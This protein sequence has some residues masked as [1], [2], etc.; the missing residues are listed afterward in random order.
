MTKRLFAYIGLTMLV[1]LAVVFYF[2]IYGTIFAAVFSVVFIILAVSLKA[3]RENRRV[4]ILIA[5]V[6]LISTSYLNIYSSLFELNT[7]RYNGHNVELTA[8]LRDYHI[9]NDYF[10]YELSC[11]EINNNADNSKIL[12]QTATD[13]GADYG[14]EIYCKVKLKRMENNY[15][16]SQGFK[17]SAYTEDYLLSYTVK[18]VKNKGAEA[19]PVMIKERLTYAM[20]VLMPGYNGELSGAISLGD[21][22]SLSDELYNAF[23]KTGLSYIIVVSG[24]HMTIAA[25]YIFLLSS[26]FGKNGLVRMIGNIFVILFILLYIAVTGFSPSATRAGIMI[27]ILYLGRLFRRRTDAFN[28][29][30]FA[31]L[32]LTIFNPLSVGDVGM[33]MSFSSVVGILKLEP[34][35]MSAFDRKFCIRKKNLYFL[36]SAA[37][38]RTDIIRIELKINLI[39]LLRAVCEMF[40]VSLS[41]VI[42]ISPI[43]LGFFGVCNP[44]VIIY[45][46]LISPFIGLLIVFSVLSS[47]LWYIP[48]IKFLSYGTAFIANLIS[49]WIVFAVNLIASI[50]YISFYANPLYMRI[51][52][53]LTMLFTASAFMFKNRRR[54]VSIAVLLSVLALVS[55]FSIKLIMN[56]DKTEL[57]VLKSGKGT[58][59]VLQSPDGVDILSCG[60][61]SSLYEYISEVIHTKSDSIKTL[62][63]PEAR[64][65]REMRYAERIL[66]EFDVEKVMLYYRYNTDEGVYRK[67]RECKLYRE[68][69]ENGSVKL[70][71]S[72]T[73][74]DEL[75]NI[76][77]STWQYVS[78]GVTSVLI[79]PYK[80]K[81]YELPDK[82]KSPDYLIT[83]GGIDDVDEI[84]Y[85][86]EILTT[87]GAMSDSFNIEFN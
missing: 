84:D 71:L 20:S 24:L 61:S 36:R 57:S 66:K 75:V 26:F 27:I 1:T 21:K 13:L 28:N 4:Y 80:G 45:S 10:Y 25:G 29:L 47:L 72:E 77:N 49:A 22:F 39:K 76:N 23:K 41:A 18:S 46:V 64:E 59:V 83:C 9:S 87:S 31:A 68:F 44:F 53:G 79:A 62:V 19:L 69:K 52:L 33:L 38:N 43:T 12:L 50:P 35:I 82:Y 63:V 65:K 8:I 86:E 67:A 74:T 54:S 81:A 30:G 14:D 40:A 3:L 48:V 5:A 15:Y 60:G 51:W 16:K 58:T 78:D 7:E 56:A 34:V 85:G 32:F 70:K 42:A 55:G 2:G 11:N 6:I 37:V 73:V 17:Y